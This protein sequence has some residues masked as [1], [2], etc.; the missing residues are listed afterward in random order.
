MERYL[1]IDHRVS[2]L[3][4]VELFNIINISS[5]PK[6][7][8]EWAVN[9]EDLRSSHKKSGTHGLCICY[10]EVIERQVSLSTLRG[11]RTVS[12]NSSFF[13]YFDGHHKTTIKEL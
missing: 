6:I 4:S 7:T 9:D 1:K 3:L 12:I 13:V 11:T 2:K 5:S 8:M 10:L